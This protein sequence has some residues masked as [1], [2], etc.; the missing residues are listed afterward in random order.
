MDFPAEGIELSVLADIVTQRLHIPIVYDEQI[1][2]KKVIIRVPMKVPEDALLG[3]LQTALRLKQMALIDAEQPGWKQIVPA[4]TLAAVAKAAGGADNTGPLAQVFILEHA[5]PKKI[6]EIVK[7]FLTQP[8]GYVQVLPGQSAIIIGDYAGAIQRIEP[9]IKKLDTAPATQTR[10]YRLKAIAPDR[11][12]SLVKAMLGESTAQREYQSAVDRDSQ[13][14]VVS[15]TPRVHDQLDEMLRQLDAPLPQ[16][17]NPMQFYKL[18]NTKAAELL[19]T[20]SGLLSDQGTQSLKPVSSTSSTP[21]SVGAAFSER[22][23]Q[24]AALKDAMSAGSNTAGANTSPVGAGNGTNSS[25]PLGSSSSPTVGSGIQSISP[26]LPYNA[27]SQESE[28][29]GL[30]AMRSRDATVAADVNTN[31]IIVIA[32]PPVQ[33]MYADLI[34]RLDSRRPQVQVECTIVTLDTSDGFSFGVDI[35][36]LAS[37]NDSQVLTLSSFG[38]S[39]VDTSTGRLSPV[40]SPGGT[41]AILN[42]NVAD[43][44][45]RTL[46][47]NSRARFVSAPQLLVNDNGRG[48]LQSVSQQPYAVILDASSTQSLT[49]LG[50]QAQAGTSITVEPHISEADYLQLGYA[51]ELSN[52]TGNASNGLPP[53]SQKNSVESSV[54]IPD[55]Y[56]II[57]GGLTTKSTGESV[58][59]LPI[60]SQL[61]L[62]GWLFGNRNKTAHDQTLFVF[63]RPVILRDDKFEDLKYLS[64]R[65]THVADIPGDFPLSH[66]IPMR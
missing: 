43:V 28:R 51:I 7:P 63:I 21:Q 37:V 55:G 19:S 52:F 54:T 26:V 30:L 40:N 36:H 47:S 20:I 64:D 23:E 25:S 39:Q 14:L 6:E 2:G 9:L 53:P 3:I 46:A 66:P 56:T 17:Q 38:I 42:P 44:V 27:P 41:F 61:P 32:P 35:S 62:V 31:S 8:G 11:V 12:D 45:I 49:S 57:V 33:A 13:T 5:D 22:R 58:N 65:K 10:V 50:G 24:A 4:P 18:K 15:A 34:T 48:I 1:Q 16:A 60:L 59:G 29:P